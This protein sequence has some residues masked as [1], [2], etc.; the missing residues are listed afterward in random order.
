MFDGELCLSLSGSHIS[1]VVKTLEQLNGKHAFDFDID[2]TQELINVNI[3]LQSKG[4][5]AMYLTFAMT[6]YGHL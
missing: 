5:L 1:W 3:A 2:L 6:K 4:L